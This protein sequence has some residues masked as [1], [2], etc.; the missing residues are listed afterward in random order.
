VSQK[1]TDVTCPLV[2]FLLAGNLLSPRPSQE[3]PGQAIAPQT[4]SGDASTRLGS[5]KERPG[6]VYHVGG[7]VKPPRVVSSPQPAPSKEEV[8]K[9]RAGKR[10]VEAGSAILA[11][12][13][14]EDGCVH[15][16]KVERS[17]NREF[18]AKAVD[19]VRQWK[20]EPATRKGT[21]VS[22]QLEVKV[23]FHLYK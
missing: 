20:F 8:E 5:K 9:A 13:V 3:L 1:A 17:L 21:P 22:V 15:S 14:G 7:D 2:F 18:D 10:V 19:A 16:V 23:D 4:S 6:R 11:I 12:V